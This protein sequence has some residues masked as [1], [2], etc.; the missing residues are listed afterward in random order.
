M[1]LMCPPCCCTTQACFSQCA[2]VH[3][4]AGESI[5]T[6][7][8]WLWYQATILHQENVHSIRAAYFCSRF[9][10]NNASFANTRNANRNHHVMHLKGY[11]KLEYQKGVIFWHT[12]YILSHLISWVRVRN[13]V[14]NKQSRHANWQ[15][16]MVSFGLCVS[17]ASWSQVFRG[18]PSG[19]FQSTAGGMPLD[20]ASMNKCSACEARVFLPGD[21]T[22]WPNTEGD[23]QRWEKIDLATLS[24]PWLRTLDSDVAA[25]CRPTRRN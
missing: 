3:H 4:P 24:S 22:I 1:C 2:V 6:D 12:L 19:R 14:H 7:D 8:T 16:L 23:V 11:R 15:A 5:C 25:E 17:S 9:N 20:S 18:Q 21:S 13:D 10:E